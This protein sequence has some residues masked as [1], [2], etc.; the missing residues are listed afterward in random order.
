M[1]FLKQ[2]FTQIV[3]GFF[4]AVFCFGILKQILDP[5]FSKYKYFEQHFN[6][7][8]VYDKYDYMSHCHLIKTSDNKKI[9]LEDLNIIILIGTGDS[10]VKNKNVTYFMLYKKDRRKI[11]YDM[12][13]KKLKFLN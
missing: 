4:G 8:V 1:K 7:L 11:F 3:L 6:G 2:N 10:I 5:N 13:H 9:Y 12:Y